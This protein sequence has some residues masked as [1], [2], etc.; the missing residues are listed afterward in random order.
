MAG[1]VGVRHG[2]YCRGLGVPAH[3]YSKKVNVLIKVVRY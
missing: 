3:F 2:G 1:T